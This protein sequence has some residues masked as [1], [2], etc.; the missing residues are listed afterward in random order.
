MLTHA[1]KHCPEELVLYA[2]LV[3]IGAIPVIITVAQRTTF[4]VE[5]TVGLLMV[6]AGLL[7]ALGCAWRAVSDRDQ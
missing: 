6:A 7:G 4:G 2:L 1:A 5:A 3:L